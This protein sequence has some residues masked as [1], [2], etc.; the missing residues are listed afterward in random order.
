MPDVPALPEAEQMTRDISAAMIKLYG[1]VYGRGHT[2]AEIYINC[3][4]VVCI[5]Q[6]IPTA[7]GTQTTG[8]AIIAEPPPHRGRE[9]LRDSHQA[10]TWVAAR[11]ADRAQSATRRP[12]RGQHVPTTA[13]LF[14]GR[15]P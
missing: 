14:L 12:F 6:D 7:R 11:H 3:N 4:V 10:R 8:G 9:S 2:S 13:C 1:E 15:R 5:V